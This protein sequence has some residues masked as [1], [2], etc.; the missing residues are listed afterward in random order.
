MAFPEG[1][2]L[3]ALAQPQLERRQSAPATHGTLNAVFLPA[4]IRF[5]AGDA[6]VKK[7]RR[8]G[9][10]RMP[11]S[12]AQAQTSLSCARHD[13]ATGPAHRPRRFRVSP[14]RCLTM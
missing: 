12:L 5:N 2:G 14:K 9:A 11:W 10:W 6:Q 1:P 4:V 8:L 3:R 7:D 13:G